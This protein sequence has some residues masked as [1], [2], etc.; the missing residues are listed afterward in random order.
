M[1]EIINA[2]ADASV[3]KPAADLLLFELGDLAR[4]RDHQDYF[5]R[6]PADAALAAVYNGKVVGAAAGYLDRDICGEQTGDFRILQIAVTKTMRSN[7]ELRVGAQLLAGIEHSALKLG[8]ISVTL[9]ALAPSQ[10][11][12][13]RNGYLHERGM[14]NTKT[15]IV[16]KAQAQ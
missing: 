1:I 5:D 13:D 14:R 2:L 15:L 12:Y 16:E 6:I 4:N 9:F 3:R 8:A 10:K 11:F 7:S